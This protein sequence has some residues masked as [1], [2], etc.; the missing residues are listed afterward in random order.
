MDRYVI[1]ISWAKHNGPIA[2]SRSDRSRSSHWTTAR[3]EAADPTH[4][5]G[6]KQ[7]L[8]RHGRPVDEEIVGDVSRAD[9]R[10]RVAS[11]VAPPP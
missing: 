11:G 4:E 6:G 2:A 8:A 5:L 9:V 7:V 3:V 10:M 1:T